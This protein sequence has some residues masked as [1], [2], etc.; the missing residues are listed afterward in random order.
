MTAKKTGPC[1]LC[2][3]PDYNDIPKDLQGTFDCPLVGKVCPTCCKYDFN[4]GM[5]AHDTAEQVYRISRKTPQEAHETCRTCPHGGKHVGEPGKWLGVKP[6]A[7]KMVAEMR[8]KD[9]AKLAWLRGKGEK[10]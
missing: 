9:L 7:H 10:P 1:K 8:K 6:G 3:C 2:K 4:A 5:A